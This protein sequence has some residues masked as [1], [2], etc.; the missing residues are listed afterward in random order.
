M[1]LNGRIHHQKCWFH[2]I[3]DPVQV[4]ELQ[5]KPHPPWHQDSC[6]FFLNLYGIAEMSWC[7]LQRYRLLF[8]GQEMAWQSFFEFPTAMRPFFT[9]C[10]LC[11]RL[12]QDVW[13]LQERGIASIAAVSHQCGGHSW[14]VRSPKLLG[15]PMS[16]TVWSLSQRAQELVV[17]GA[18]PHCGSLSPPGWH[19]YGTTYLWIIYLW[20]MLI[21]YSCVS[22]LEVIM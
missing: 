21:F 9:V 19:S 7:P 2:G 22:L 6:L 18:V 10:H 16:E 20:K 14:Q 5:V 12:W 4:A 11:W 15:R 8:L 1:I 13:G 3:F 17:N